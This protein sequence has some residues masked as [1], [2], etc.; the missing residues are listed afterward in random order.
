MFPVPYYRYSATDGL[1][2]YKMRQA[3]NGNEL[4]NFCPTIIEDRYDNDGKEIA[5]L[6]RCELPDE[7]TD[8][9]ITK[10]NLKSGYSINKA[11]E[12]QLSIRQYH[13]KANQA[14]RIWLAMN[15]GIER[16]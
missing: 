3:L 9:L 11:M 15:Q 12:R 6:V 7:F 5:H 8:I 4:A 16:V 10:E 13:W 1:M 14:Y 2:H